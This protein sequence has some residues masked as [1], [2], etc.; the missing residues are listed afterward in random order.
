M[1]IQHQLNL[2]NETAHLEALVEIFCALGVDY[3]LRLTQKEGRFFVQCALLYAQGVPLDS[4]GATESLAKLFPDSK[5]PA[6]RVYQLRMK[7]KRKNWLLE[8]QNSLQI[9]PF[10]DLRKNDLWNIDL[11]LKMHYKKTGFNR[12]LHTSAGST[13]SPQNT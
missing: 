4:Q 9:H 5:D 11:H 8:K 1:K 3:K 7:L 12:S 13:V 2:K 6:Q 10:F